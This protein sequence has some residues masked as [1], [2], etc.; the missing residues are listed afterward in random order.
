MQF[1]S[2][3]H[4]N[5]YLF[6]NQATNEG[7]SSGVVVS[8]EASESDDEEDESTA[9]M[10]LT[11]NFPT[12]VSQQGLQEFELQDDCTVSFQEQKQQF[13]S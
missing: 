7:P 8:G 11:R 1:K 12:L 9:N 4:N 6:V 13:E 2:T 3:R 5:I 10:M